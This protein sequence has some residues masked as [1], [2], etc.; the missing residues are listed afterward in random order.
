MEMEK[1]KKEDDHKIAVQGFEG[2]HTI[3]D[4]DEI[5]LCVPTRKCIQFWAQIIACFIVMIVGLSLAIVGIFHPI[6]T[7]VNVNNQT[8]I[9]TDPLPINIGASLFFLAFGIL[10]PAPYNEAGKLKFM[11]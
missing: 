2:D 8:F 7:T 10:V 5:R 6:T 11:Q 4:V 3:L 1:I 9:T